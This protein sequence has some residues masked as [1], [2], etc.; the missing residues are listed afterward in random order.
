MDFSPPGYAL[1]ALLEAGLLALA[2]VVVVRWWGL[3]AALVL[4]EAAQ[5]RF[6][7]GG[8]P[9]PGLAH[10]QPDGPFVLAGPLG[11]SLLVTGAAATA[12]V[13]LAALCLFPTARS[14]AVA[15]ATAVIIAAL[16]L[17]V[18]SA[19]TTSPAGHSMPSSCRAADRAAP[20]RCSPTLTT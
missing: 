4:L 6:P 2:A 11:G 18:G 12:G 8:F 16:P 19:I 17:L 9:L 3:P 15:A 13:A 10:S 5:T 1:M 14:R 7:L 20:E